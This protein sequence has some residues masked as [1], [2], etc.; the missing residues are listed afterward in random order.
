VKEPKPTFHIETFYLNYIK[1]VI[2]C[3]DDENNPQTIERKKIYR[4][5]N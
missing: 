4:K 1:V 3:E 2:I 5:A